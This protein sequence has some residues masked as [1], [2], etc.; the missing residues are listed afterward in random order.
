MELSEIYAGLGRERF[1]EVL[2]SVSMGSLKT[3]QVYETFKVRTRLSKLN[4]DRLRKAG[5]RL[6]ARIAEGDEDVAK[7][8]A[9]GALVSNMEFVVEA[10]DFLGIAHD[11]SGFFDKDAEASE[12]LTEGWQG[13][14]FSEFRERFSEALVLLYINHLDWEMGEPTEV[15]LG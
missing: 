13:R 2:A 5:P 1:D 10:L 14:L 7:E 12:K 9:Q 3:F 8:I 11:G 15:F 6:W 4:R